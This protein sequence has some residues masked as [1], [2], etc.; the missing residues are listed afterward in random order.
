MAD[1]TGERGRGVLTPTDRA[2][3]R[4]EKEYKNEETATHRRADIRQRVRDSIMDFTLLVEELPEEDRNRI[5]GPDADDETISDQ[6]MADMIAFLAM[7]VEQNPHPSQDTLRMPELEDLI[8]LGIERALLVQGVHPQKI[9]VDIDVQTY[10]ERAVELS[11]RFLEGDQDVHST[12]GLITYLLKTQ[13]LDQDKLN[14]FLRSEVEP[15]GE[16]SDDDSP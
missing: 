5:F 8:Q 13:Q 15:V 7:G 3:L 1:D 9:S 11:R 10:N 12:S 4:G 16:P 14:E 2:F 6:A